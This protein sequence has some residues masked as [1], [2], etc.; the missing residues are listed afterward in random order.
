MIKKD[1]IMELFELD[2]YEYSTLEEETLKFLSDCNEQQLPVLVDY[3]GSYTTFKEHSEFTQ[4]FM[5]LNSFIKEFIS[6]IKDILNKEF[7]GYIDFI[8]GSINQSALL[9]KNRCLLLDEKFEN[10]IRFNSEENMNWKNLEKIIL[11]VVPEDINHKIKDDVYEVY[12][13]LEIE[14]ET[15]EDEYDF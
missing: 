5:L 7:I 3:W 1:T 8:D 15:D 10:F 12:L 9:V 14:C 6:P 13:E 4:H 2:Q 11:E